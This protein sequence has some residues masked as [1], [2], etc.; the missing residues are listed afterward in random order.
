MRIEAIALTNFKAF[1]E[2][3]VPLGALTLLSGLNGSGKSSVVQA[4]GLLRQ[5]LDGG[6]LR[7]G[8]IALNGPL[9]EIGTGRDLLYQGFAN[10]MIGISL[11]VDAEPEPQWLEWTAEA[12]L[13]A[14]V[15]PCAMPPD[16]GA[17]L[18]VNVFNAGFQFL[19]ADRITPALTFPRSQHAVGTDRF[20]GARG[21]Y[22][23]HFLL[24]YGEVT[25][26]AK[27]L[28]HTSAPDAPGL[29]SQVNAWMQEFSPGV[30]VEPQAIPM[31]DLVRLAFS[32][33]G[34]SAAYGEP[35]RPTN[36]G[37]GLTHAL[38]VVTACLAAEPGSLV[39]IENPEAQ[40]HPLGQAAMGRLL[41]LAAAQ[42]VQILAESHSDHVLNGIRIAVKEGVIAPDQ[43]QLHFFRRDIG[44]GAERET[45]ML[46]TEGRLSFR[47]ENYF[48]QW[49]RSLDALLDDRP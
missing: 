22:T 29:L 34:T 39:V 6:T 11:K 27:P 15:L 41:A 36:V 18:D 47:P 14:D 9:V 26:V 46:S 21:E 37:F 2:V 20:L 3:E 38:P 12:P 32:Y 49:E 44:K 13:D 35:M 42:G 10:A 17:A 43:V 16:E 28:R 23:A 45:P 40:L 8:E 7:E 25:E 48:D 33:R 4:L 19:R 1:D 30:R 31:T 5:S 24:K